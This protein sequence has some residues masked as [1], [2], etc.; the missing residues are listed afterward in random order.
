MIYPLP[1]LDP[2]KNWDLFEVPGQ[3]DPTNPSEGPTEV[4]DQ[5]DPT[6]PTGCPTDQPP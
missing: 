6:D 1:A 4:P 2:P 3:A 5:A